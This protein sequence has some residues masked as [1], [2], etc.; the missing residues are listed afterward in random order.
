MKAIGSDMQQV[1]F[2]VDQGAGEVRIA[3]AA[4]VPATIIGVNEG[5]KGSTLNAGNYQSARRQFA[6]E[7]LRP[8]WAGAAGALASILPSRPGRGS[9][10]TTATSR[11]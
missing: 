2:K 9:G 10:T 4:R 11:S 7:L 5:L 6:D 1:D 3:I 8:Y